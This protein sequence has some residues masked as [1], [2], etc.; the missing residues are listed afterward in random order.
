MRLHQ[1]KYFIKAVGFISVFLL[2]IS[3]SAGSSEPGQFSFLTYN[4]AGL[5]DFISQSNPARYNKKISPLLNNFDVVVVQENFSYHKDLISELEH[6][7]IGS[8]GKAGTLGDGLAR[9][10]NTRFS[11]VDHVAW[12][13]CY[14]MLGHANDCLTPKGYSFAT[15]EI[16]PG[17]FIDIYNLHM[18]AGKSEGDIAAKDV[19]IDQLIKR[20]YSTSK[21]KA[22]IVAGDW[23]LRKDRAD[24][25]KL[26]ERMFIRAGLADA[27]E[28]LGCGDDRIDR[29]MFRSGGD[30][31]LRPIKW[32]VENEMFT[33]QN[34]IPLSDHKAV[35]VL[36]E[37]TQNGD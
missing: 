22:V 16:A 17:I 20:I 11:E 29:V 31:E 7:F 28:F 37:Y 23:N 3:F 9:F 10:S 13:K 25:T 8:N 6:N 4:V 15:H 12:Q 27:C 35:S 21:E 18:D 19:Q 14:G 32:K 33:T 1:T 34:G 30:I 36:F 2:V 24:K 5:P 26:L